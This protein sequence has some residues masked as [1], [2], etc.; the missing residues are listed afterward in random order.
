MAGGRLPAA[1]L[2]HVVCCMSLLAPP[3][4]AIIHQLRLA[5]LSGAAQSV[6]SQAPRRLRPSWRISYPAAPLLPLP[7]WATLRLKPLGCA[8]ILLSL[9]PSS[10]HV[11]STCPSASPLKLHWKEVTSSKEC[12]P[13][14]ARRAPPAPASLRAQYLTTSTGCEQLWVQYWVV[15]PRTSSSNFPLL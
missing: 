15:E 9:H 6:P 2:S 3:D 10:R 7:H 14:G 4:G 11:S 5:L 13:A 12:S 1:S 8:E